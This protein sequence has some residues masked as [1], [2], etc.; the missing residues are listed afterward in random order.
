VEVE[1][2]GGAGVVVARG[3]GRGKKGEEREEGGI[4]AEEG[5][6]PQQRQ[7]KGR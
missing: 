1:G 4:E 7:G 5:W 6:K 3:W 2:V